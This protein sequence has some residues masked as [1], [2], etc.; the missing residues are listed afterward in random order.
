MSS[1]IVRQLRRRSLGLDLKEGNTDGAL[2]LIIS[3]VSG[4]VGGD[5]AGGVLR[6]QSLGP[7]GDSIAGISGGG[8]GGQLL[9]ATGVIGGAQAAGAGAPAGGF[10]IGSLIGQV[11]GGGVGGTIL[12]II[13]GLIKQAVAK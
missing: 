3:L 1:P 5:V 12:M 9:S 8:F 13:V 7:V 4:A 6:E 11:A 10:D 2:G